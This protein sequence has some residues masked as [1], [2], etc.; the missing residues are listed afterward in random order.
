MQ[1]SA[2]TR[3]IETGLA[4][5]DA[6]WSAVAA[7]AREHLCAARRVV[8]RWHWD[9]RPED[10]GV[11][12]PQ[13]VGRRTPC[14]RTAFIWALPMACPRRMLLRRRAMALMM[15]LSM[16]RLNATTPLVWGGT[17]QLRAQARPLAVRPQPTAIGP[18]RTPG[19]GKG[20]WARESGASWPARLVLWRRREGVR[21]AAA[22]LVTVWRR[23]AA[24]VLCLVAA[25][26]V[27]AGRG[28]RQVERLRGLVG[29]G[30]EAWTWGPF[31]LRWAWIR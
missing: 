30:A 20:D 6:R 17:R 12:D 10:E 15:S 27:P 18:T 3:G 21:L 9:A 8:R 26:H 1:A 5:V 22:R 7:R 4:L 11:L 23:G 19:A 16:S 25:R 31:W 24:T 14:R 2:W 28:E 13:F 29:N